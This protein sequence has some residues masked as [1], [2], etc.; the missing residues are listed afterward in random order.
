MVFPI[1]KH[2]YFLMYLPKER[3]SEFLYDCYH[4]NPCISPGILES[5]RIPLLDV[6]QKSILPAEFPLVID[7]GSSNT[8]MGICLSDGTMQIATVKA[9][10]II[11]SLVGVCR[12]AGEEAQFVFG[13]DAKTLFQENYRD[14]DIAVFYDI[15]RW[16]SNPNRSEAV[17]LPDGYKYQFSRKE[18]LRAYLEYLFNLA[19]Q[20]FKCSFTSIQMLAPI[21]QREK[22]EEFF[23]DLLPRV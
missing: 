20:Q 23:K 17:I 3:D 4:N 22:F 12:N 8:T 10:E 1:E 16:I 6:Q 15:K 19:Q 2:Q 11:P 7:L 14:N 18:M 5:I 9:S 21:R 13:H